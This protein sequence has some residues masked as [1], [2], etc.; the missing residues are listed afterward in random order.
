MLANYDIFKDE[1]NGCYQIRSKTAT[2]IVVFDEEASE[3]IFLR[4][5][6]L[7]SKG[8]RTNLQRIRK[9][10]MNDFE[11]DKVLSVLHNLREAGLI[12]DGTDLNAKDQSTFR[13]IGNAS[14]AIIGNSKLTEA[15]KKVSELDNFKTVS[16]FEY[17]E[18]GFEEK[19]SKVFKDY[20]FVIVDAHLW[21]PHHLE[22]INKTAVKLNK[23]WLYIPGFNEENIEIGP[24]FYGK[25]T[26][27]YNCLISRIK[28][29][30]SYPQYLS[31]YEKYLRDLKK[32]SSTMNIFHDSIL[33]SIVAN[34]AIY[35]TIKFIEG[36]ALPITWQSVFKINMYNYDTSVHTLLKKP[37][38]E[39]CKPNVK[40][41]PAPW[42]DKVT[43]K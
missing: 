30:H 11:E 14:L 39:V 24:L 1:D 13:S 25:E 41:N 15:L 16:T 27:C 32:S 12:P 43:L 5:V 4:I 29:N 21:S 10:L 37:L 6:D 17:E 2:F 20:D 3:K 7:S 28:S 9:V 33:Y 19:V 34:F 36:W 31:Q 38:C 23:P 40:Y 18:N 22:I 8:K 26:G 35:E 42:L